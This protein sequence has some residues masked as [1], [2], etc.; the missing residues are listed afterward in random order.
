MRLELAAGE[1]TGRWLGSWRG[2]PHFQEVGRLTSSGKNSQFCGRGRERGVSP[3]W[4]MSKYIVLLLIASP[5]QLLE[6]LMTACSQNNTQHRFFQLRSAEYCYLPISRWRPPRTLVM[7]GSPKPECDPTGRFPRHLERTLD[8]PCQ[9][10]RLLTTS[11]QGEPD[12]LRGS[13]CCSKTVEPGCDKR[14]RAALGM[15]LALRDG[16]DFPRSWRADVE[17][18]RIGFWLLKLQSAWLAFLFLWAE[19]KKRKKKGE[20]KVYLVCILL[21]AKLET[22][23][24][25]SVKRRAEVPITRLLL[26]LFKNSSGLSC[27]FVYS[28]NKHCQGC[29]ACW[30]LGVQ[31]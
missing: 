25:S 23:R 20:G 12:P 3:A 27:C 18:E 28:F 2:F 14:P 21:R 4:F 8:I 6:V 26:L 29:A 22:F 15:P 11:F 1:G 17:R 30:T 9:L 10:I 16:E 19:E 7:P 31:W 5:D 24:P 13:L